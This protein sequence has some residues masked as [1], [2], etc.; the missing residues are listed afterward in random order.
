MTAT[1]QYFLATIADTAQKALGAPVAEV[2]I[3]AG[4]VVIEVTTEDVI[5]PFWQAVR[6]QE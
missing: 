1:R 6:E 4:K 2:R 3:E 5:S